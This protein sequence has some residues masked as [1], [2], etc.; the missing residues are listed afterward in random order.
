MIRKYLIN[1]KEYTVKYDDELKAI[2]IDPAN[3]ILETVSPT[4]WNY[5]GHTNNINGVA[6]ELKCE[7][8]GILMTDIIEKT[9]KL[10]FLTNDDVT[11]TLTEVIIYPT[12]TDFDNDE[13]YYLK[14]D[15]GELLETYNYGED[16][17]VAYNYYWDNMNLQQWFCDLDVN[18]SKE[19]REDGYMGLKVTC[20]EC[21]SYYPQ[22]R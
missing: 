18:K 4:Q 10:E 15:D 11:T 8:D 3:D 7:K 16:E 14:T 19:F 2:D 13:E 12:V 17:S 22:E 9:F 1:E 5:I 21:D 6:I 20:V